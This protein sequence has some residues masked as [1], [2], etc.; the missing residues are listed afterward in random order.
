[1]LQ[2]WLPTLRKRSEEVLRPVSIADM[3]EDFWR[4]PFGLT[5][6]PGGFPKGLFSGAGEFP[7]VNVSETEK[8][9]TVD[10]ELPGLE[11]K[12]VNVSLENDSLVITGEKKFEGEEKKKNYHRIERSY[13]SF[14]RT[15][16]LPA[17]VSPKGV[18]A[19]FEKGVLHVTLAK[20]APSA[21]AQKIKIEG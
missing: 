12:D 20:A 7:A 18:K 13:G 3:L 2:Q 15:V 17:K 21:P 6:L 14:T 8:Q 9:I 1:M 10:A 11:A 19:R 5:R 16:P 4:N